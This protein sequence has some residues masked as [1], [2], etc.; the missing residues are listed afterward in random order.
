MLK[1]TSP[2]E[3]AIWREFACALAH[4]P[5]RTLLV[6]E[7]DVFLTAYRERLPDIAPVADEWAEAY[8]ALDLPEWAEWVATDADGA[9]FSCDTMPVRDGIAFTRWSYAGGIK[10]IGKIVRDNWRDSLRR[11]VRNNGKITFS[12]ET[13]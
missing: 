5:N 2:E 13:P 7:A 12:K 3:A 10:R 4:A 6:N 9:T 1:F 11:V 8:S